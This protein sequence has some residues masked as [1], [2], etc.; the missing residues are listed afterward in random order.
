MKAPLICLVTDLRRISPDG[1]RALCHD[2]ADA[3]IDLIQ[4][5]EPQL[6][7]RELVGMAMVAVHETRGSSTRV[8][9]NGRLDV[10]RAVD[11]DGVH[12][13]ASGVPVARA[14]QCGP[15]DRP[16]WLLGRSAHNAAELEA[17][18]DADYIVFGTVF[19]TDSKPGVAGQGIEALA[20]AVRHARAP[21]L[22]IGGMTPDRIRACAKVGAA[23]VA[24]IT[25]FLKDA[26]GGMSPRDAVRMI[27][28]QFASD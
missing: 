24:G 18:A 23:G 26:P 8:V 27:R 22:A 10:A 1:F 14:R 25:L 4:I 5:R 16:R 28:E 7:A 12:L 3:S 21:V 9:V 2:A 6:N 11:A 20:A 19:A 15:L 13:P 17:A